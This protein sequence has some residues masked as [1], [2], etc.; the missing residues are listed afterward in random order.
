M[1]EARG[2]SIDELFDEGTAIDEALKKAVREELLKHK[3]L[4][5]PIVVWDGYK[6]VWIP[7]EE[8]DQGDSPLEKQPRRGI[9]ALAR[10]TTTTWDCACSYYPAAVWRSQC[11][12]ITSGPRQHLEQPV[13]QIPSGCENSPMAGRG[14]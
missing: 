13:H 5:N 9:R 11:P 1:D 10:P 6:V 7:P 2:K 4:G 14:G 3:K 8:I 12:P